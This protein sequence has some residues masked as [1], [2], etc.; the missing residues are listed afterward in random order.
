MPTLLIRPL[1]KAD[2][3]AVAQIVTQ[4]DMFPAEMLDDMTAPYFADTQGDR[5]WLVLEQGEVRA[6][7]YHVPEPL[8]DGTCNLLLIAV[9]P[10]AQG[11]GLGTA[12]MARIESDLAAAGARILLVETSGKEEFARTR[13]FYAMLGYDAEAMIRDYYADGDDKVIFRKRL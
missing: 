1:D 12:L 10:V 11:R 4:T 9:D 7:A 2:L 5:R 6:V 13:A 3:P 8:T